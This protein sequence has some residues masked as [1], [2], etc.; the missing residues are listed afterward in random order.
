M[1]AFNPG[2]ADEEELRRELGAVRELSDACVIAVRDENTDLVTALLDEVVNSSGV[3]FLLLLEHWAFLLVN[4]CGDQMPG[5]ALTR[6]GGAPFEPT[7]DDARHEFLVPSPG[8]LDEAH[9]AGPGDGVVDKFMCGESEESKAYAL[10]YLLQAG[11]D[12][13][14]DLMHAALTAISTWLSPDQSEIAELLLTLVTEGLPQ[15][16]LPSSF[17]RVAAMLFTVAEP[18][19]REDMVLPLTRLVALQWAEREL[20]GELLAAESVAQIRIDYPTSARRSA[21]IALLSRALARDYAPGE[22]VVSSRAEHTSDS[23]PLDAASAVDTVDIISC[24]M[25]AL[26]AAGRTEEIPAEMKR[27]TNANDTHV[28]HVL[29]LLAH[30][31]AHVN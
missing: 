9:A 22:P 25:I 12:R 17:V 15:R 13:N 29:L 28:L 16:S 14:D 4:F 30:R 18:A 31:L 27:L 21:A 2:G 3:R 1:T 20:G 5:W 8:G 6:A 24:R 10:L 23:S 11:V 26:A 7:T 19:G